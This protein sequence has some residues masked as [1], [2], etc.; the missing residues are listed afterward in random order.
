ME[1]EI[2]DIVEWFEE[3]QD[4]LLAPA[5]I[6]GVVILLGI[7]LIILTGGSVNFIVKL[8]FVIML[9]GAPFL[10]YFLGDYIDPYMSPVFEKMGEYVMQLRAKLNM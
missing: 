4:W 1:F 8:L 2:Q 3:N 10:G 6:N 9:F 7:L 5:I